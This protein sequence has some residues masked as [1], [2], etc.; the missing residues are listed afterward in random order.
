MPKPSPKPNIYATPL[1]REEAA[2]LTYRACEILT[3]DNPTA[4]EIKDIHY[5][6]GI[7]FKRK[8][9][10]ISGVTADLDGRIIVPRKVK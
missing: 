2:K 9:A 3:R 1:D 8:L 4:D 10:E 6:L 7:A 5:Q